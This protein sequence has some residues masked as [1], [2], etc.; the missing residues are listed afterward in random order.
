MKK[1]LSILCALMLLC[2]SVFPVCAASPKISVKTVSSA[3]VGDTITV[4]VNLSANSGLAGIQFTVK[5]N[6]KEFQLVSDSV[7]TSNLFVANTNINGGTI[8]YAGV[9]ANAINSSGTLLTFKLKVIKTG[10][11]ITLAIN[12]AIDENN[13]FVSVTTS[14]ATVKCSHADMKWNV[15]KGATCT[16]NGEKKG[17]C[18]CGHTATETVN[19]VAHTYGKWTT[20][21]EAT[22]TEKGLKWAKCSV[23]G[24]KK[25]QTIPMLTTTTEST[26]E[27]TTFVENTTENTT[28]S[29]TNEPTTA[30]TAP[31]VEKTSVAEIVIKTVAVVLGIEALGLLVF[32]MGKK[33]K[34]K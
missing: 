7:K 20:E 4:S 18:T 32:L 30:P 22:E 8:K 19:K 11:K 16:E 27:T 5:F 28:E 24:E 26:T 15:T 33:K 2:L 21:K 29:T 14:G 3:S 1:I 10:G 9:S 31:I 17:T 34:Q 12:D 13:N 6:T 25:E 23:C